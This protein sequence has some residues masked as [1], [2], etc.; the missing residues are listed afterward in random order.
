MHLPATDSDLQ[1]YQPA[2]LPIQDL[3]HVL[4]SFC[5]V[6][7]DGSVV[8]SDTYADLQKHYPNDSWND[9]GNNVY[10]VAKQLYLLKKK[11]R[12]MKTLLSI[13]G[14]RQKLTIDDS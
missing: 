14:L 6:Q 2:N 7:S 3:T 11:N 13:G 10:G 9:V 5:N 4:Y 8:L 1:N 12:N